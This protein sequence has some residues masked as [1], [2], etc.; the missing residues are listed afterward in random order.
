MKENQMNAI[1]VDNECFYSDHI[2]VRRPDILTIKELKQCYV[3]ALPHEYR[4]L[5][6]KK[7]H[8][9]P[10]KRSDSNDIE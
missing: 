2:I 4:P 8:I 10:R 9:V 6:K 7:N 1:S 3:N 5:R